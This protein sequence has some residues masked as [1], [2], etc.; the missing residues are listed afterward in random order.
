MTKSFQVLA[1]VVLAVA[2]FGCGRMGGLP[3]SG[4][5]VT[6]S[7]VIGPFQRVEAAGNVDVV[8]VKGERAVEVTTDENLLKLIETVV[9]EDGTL[10][11]RVISPIADNGGLKVTVTNPV[12]EGVEVS[13]AST[14]TGP[15]ANPADDFKIDVS[16]ASRVTLSGLIASKVIV[17]VSGASEVIL[18]QGS[19]TTLTL[20]A[21]GA[22]Q[23]ASHG[24]TA[25][26]VRVEVS[27][28]SSVCVTAN[29]SI[30][31]N[32]SGGSTVTVSG[33]PKTLEVNS[34]G[35]SR[36]IKEG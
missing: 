34:S 27:G 36:L 10:V 16:G 23:F 35:G 11:V 26:D 7:R 31:G 19:S 9:R 13:G 12:L 5:I 24:F 17:N 2:L 33:G 18:E 1:A 14:F 8:F 15:A 21:T 28:A 32:A 3:G 22:S 4:K 30:S 29:Q 25:H 6:E 20:T